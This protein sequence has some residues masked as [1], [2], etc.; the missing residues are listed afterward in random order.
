MILEEVLIILSTFDLLE[1]CDLSCLYCLTP[2]YFSSSNSIP[3]FSSFTL[4]SSILMQA[5]LSLDSSSYVLSLRTRMQSLG[6]S[7]LLPSTGENIR[8]W[9]SGH[10]LVSNLHSW[11]KCLS[12]SPRASKAL[13]SGT[14][15]KTLTEGHSR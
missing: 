13:H 6:G 7:C 1:E 5:S 9:Q 12:K 2:C 4:F 14:G 10:S 15:Q 11:L 8:D 3:H